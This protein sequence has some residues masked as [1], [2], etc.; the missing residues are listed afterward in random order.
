VCFFSF[1]LI[2]LSHHKERTNLIGEDQKT[3]T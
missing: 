2:I 3:G 1:N